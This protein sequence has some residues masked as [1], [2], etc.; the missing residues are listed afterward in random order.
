M[1]GGAGVTGGYGEDWLQSPFGHD[2]LQV[3]KKGEVEVLST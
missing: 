1:L 2:A 3:A